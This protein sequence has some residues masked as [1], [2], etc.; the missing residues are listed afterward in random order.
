MKIKNIR[1][2]IRAAGERTLDLCHPL[3]SKQVEEQ[4]IYSIKF[5]LY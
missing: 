2:V 1:V 4:N 3:V 5:L